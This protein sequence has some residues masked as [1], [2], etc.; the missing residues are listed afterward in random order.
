MN[1]EKIG[2]FIS[3]CRKEKQ[4]T[5]EQLAVQLGVTSKSISKWENGNCLPDASKYKSLCEILGITVNELFSGERLSSETE[6]EAKDYLVDLLASRIYDVDCGVSY[7]DFKNALLR[8][9]E[10]TVMLS[11]FKS[12]EDAVEYL[13]KETRLS[14]E[15]CSNAYDFYFNLYKV[16]HL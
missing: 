7:E 9:S 6:N 3:E 13:V 12:K 1:Q 11:K 15:E 4:L 16:K 2:K 5:Q 14:F 10:T 8:M